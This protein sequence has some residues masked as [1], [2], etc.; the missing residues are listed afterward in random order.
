MK[1]SETSPNMEY[2]VRELNKI[3]IKIYKHEKIYL[4]NNIDITYFGILFLLV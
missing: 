1:K 2:P 3:I 4:N